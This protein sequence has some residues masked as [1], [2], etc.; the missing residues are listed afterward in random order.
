MIFSISMD[1]SM[2]WNN[3]SFFIC[4]DVSSFTIE[5]IMQNL[6]SWNCLPVYKSG[7]LLTAKKSSSEQISLFWELGG[8]I[9]RNTTVRTY[10]KRKK[11]PKA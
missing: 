5:K 9:G 6:I 3:S 7:F 2:I 1:R 10:P 11:H 8:S 4:V